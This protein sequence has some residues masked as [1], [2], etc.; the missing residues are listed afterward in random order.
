MIFKDLVG[1]LFMEA[2]LIQTLSETSME[3]P[4]EEK[5]QCFHVLVINHH[6]AN[7][8]QVTHSDSVGISLTGWF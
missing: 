5:L 8:L 1:G 4:L 6:T 3:R 7:D 2:F